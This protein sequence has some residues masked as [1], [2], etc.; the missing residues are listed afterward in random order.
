MFFSI[1]FRASAQVYISEVLFNPPGP[2]APNEYVELRGAPHALLPAGTYF[3][4]VEGDL[5]GNP[6]TIQNVFDLSGLRLGQ[7][8]FLLLLQNSNTFPSAPNA[9][10]LVNTNGAGFGHG[11]GSSIRHRGE[12]GQTDL[13]NTS[14]TF[15]LVRSGS[16]PSIGMDVDADN[17]GATDGTLAATW[18]VWDA[19]AVLDSD[20]PGDIG[21]GRINFRR[22][23]APGNGAT[24]LGGT[25]VPVQFTPSY[26][27]RSGNTTN[28]IAAAW[29]AGDN[30]LGA[31]PN[32]SLSLSDTTPSSHGGSPLNHVGLA[33]F[34]APNVPNLVVLQ[35]TGSTE[36]TEGSG[37]DSFTLALNSAPS[38]NVTVQVA[39]STQVQVSTNGGVTFSSGYSVVLNNT[40]PRTITVR[41]LDDTIL[42]T[43]PHAVLVTCTVVATADSNY[44]VGMSSA[45]VAVQVHEND[46]AL[47][48]ELKVNPPGAEDAPYEFLELLGAPNGLLTNVYLLVIDGDVEANP[49]TISSVID[50][51]GAQMGSIGLLVILGDGHPYTVPNGAR[52]FLSSELSETGGALDN[53]SVSFLLVSSPSPLGPGLDLDAGDNGKLEGLPM[54]TTVLDSV[55][56]V[57]G[58][59]GDIIYS[60]AKLTQGS[61]IPEAASR[62]PGNLVA[63]SAAAWINAG[64][65]GLDPRSLAYAT[66]N[67][68]AYFPYGTSLTIGAVNKLAPTT[69]PLDPVSGVI[70][71]PT[72]P[73]VSFTFH[74]PDTPAE[75]LTVTAMSSDETVVPS[76]NLVLSG[77]GNTR[78]LA[79]FPTNVG[80]STITITISGGA[81]EGRSTFAYAASKDDRGGGRF[82]T[83]V[84]DGSPAMAIDANYMFAGDDE[85]QI[86]RVFSRSNSG[87]A[88]LQFDLN[89]FLG[90]NDLYDDGTP[91]EIDL[92]GSTRVGNRLYWIGSHS[93]S[94]DSEVRTNRGRVFA[95]D[96]SGSGTN[97]QLNFVGRYDYLKLDLMMWDATNGHGRGNNYYGLAGS[98]AAG[99][100][101][102][103]VDGSGFNIEGL[104][105]A[106]GSSEVA[107][108][109]FRAPLVP[110]TNRVKSLIV[111]VLNFATLS[112]SSATNPGLARFGAPIELNLGG[113]GI[114]SI[115][116]N[117][118]GY[119]IVSGPPGVASGVPPSDFRLFSWEGTADRPAQ[120]RAASLTDLIVEGIIELPSAPWTSSSQVQVISD[121][122][123]TVFY[124]DAIEAKHLPIKQFKKFRSD[125]ITIGPVSA[126][127]PVMRSIRHSG[128]SS[129]LTWYSVVGQ[130]YRVQWKTQLS[131]TNWNDY[132]GDVVA[133]DVVSSKSV[134]VSGSA[135]RF[136]RVV[137]P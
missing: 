11:N 49:G 31:A 67:G 133:G 86:V 94:Q 117:A 69:S 84:S 35:S 89:P 74:D 33:N 17:D 136:F 104:A 137:I 57:D 56:W 62:R 90:L 7:N 52:L 15:F 106:P 68:S 130:T 132:P 121:N 32:W 78:S 123:I 135:Q 53:G 63:N 131:E 109:G 91:R 70:G 98:G 38:G 42:N 4:C 8:G 48:N 97:V 128:A 127:R 16:L 6:G 22:N 2:D 46:T 112:V 29:V 60:A 122:G 105:M 34:G 99:V 81:V 26:V 27:G 14:V 124:N 50:L 51:S 77:S 72:T 88:I 75:L 64:I 12:N 9:T 76:R 103:A 59:T 20:G 28:W 44:P 24:V 115:E 107:Y 125:W 95:T 40:S 71:D 1:F 73:A 18:N 92:E 41:A 87:P 100:D 79:I 61:G 116:G 82:H 108:I 39:A 85:N 66:Q 101:P 58:G 36:V 126:T 102:K 30:F 119:L 134:P 80:Y 47:L 111:P 114:R 45:P 96:L 5:S 65:A 129:L 43:S 19:V 13:E 113:R 93:H 55:G 10:L 110:T 118:G 21:Y 120:E 25:I 3:L 23:T 37:S 54:G 83:G